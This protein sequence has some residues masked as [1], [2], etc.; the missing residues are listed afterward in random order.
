MLKFYLIK[1]KVYNNGSFISNSCC[2]RTLLNEKDVENKIIFINW[3]NLSENYN[4]FGAELPFNFYNMK[5]GRRVSFCNW[6]PFKK[7][8]RDIDEW[9]TK[10]DIMIK[11]TYQDIDKSISIKDVLEWN[12][13]EKAIIYLNERGLKLTDKIGVE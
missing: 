2:G 11:I 5:K 7:D 10:L 6:N 9:K 8:F 1:I 12:D 13:V 3:D 4:K